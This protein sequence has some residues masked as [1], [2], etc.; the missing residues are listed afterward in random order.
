MEPSGPINETD[1]VN[2]S[3]TCEVTDGNPR[4]L[5][6]VRWYLDGDLLKELPDCTR[7]TTPV[8]TDEIATFCD[9]DPSKLLLEA[10]GRSFHGNYSCEGRNEAGW[11]PISSSTPVVVNCKISSPLTSFFSL[12]ISNHLPS[13]F[14]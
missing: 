2:V 9:I 14:F 5:I 6:A 3:L 8:T 10:V 12:Q 11:G 7:N 4:T 1:R 13:K